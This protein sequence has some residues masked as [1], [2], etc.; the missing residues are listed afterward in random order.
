MIGSKAQPTNTLMPVIARQKN[1]SIR[2]GAWVRRVLHQEGKAVGVVYIDSTGTEVFQP[3]D[4][5][6]LASWTINNTRL[7]LL[8]KIG[9][10]YDPQTGEGTAGRNLTHQAPGGGASL[11]F[12]K[13]LNRFMASGATGMMMG[14]FDA[15]NFDHSDLQFIRGASLVTGTTGNR[16]I[17]NFGSVP[18]TVK[19]RWGSEWKKA[20]IER[21]DHMAGVGGSAEHIA[22]KLNFMDLD[23]VYKDKFGDPLIRLTLDW[24]ENERRVAEHLT[25][26]AVEIGRA[27]GAREVTPGGTLGRYDVISYKSTHIQGGAIMGASPENSVV[28]SFQQHWQL[29]NLFVVGASSFPQ[30]AS[31]NPTLTVLAVTLRTADARVDRYLK[32]PGPLA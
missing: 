1:V 2:T 14:D 3:A 17:S 8:S 32:R 18:P 26:R 25:T 30:N 28:N 15:D 24:Q 31:G 7:L 23:P 4:V 27:M 12:D 13:P 10:A 19:R 21:Y 22:Y 9:Q 11:Y 16:P 5:V 20:A 29:S 6:L